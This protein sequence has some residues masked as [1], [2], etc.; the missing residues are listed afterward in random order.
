MYSSL[1]N[2]ISEEFSSQSRNESED[3]SD[4]ECVPLIDMCERNFYNELDENKKA[5]F[6]SMNDDFKFEVLNDNIG[7]IL[8]EVVDR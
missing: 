1:L 7:D 2:S 3:N 5:L 4:N 8:I 6:L